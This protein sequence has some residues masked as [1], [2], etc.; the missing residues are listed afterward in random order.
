MKDRQGRRKIIS[1]GVKD[2]SGV[3]KMESKA[4]IAKKLAVRTLI[5]FVI[6]AVAILGGTLLM[7]TLLK[8]ERETNKKNQQKKTEQNFREAM[9]KYY[10]LK[11]GDYKITERKYYDN[12]VG[13]FTFSVGGETYGALGKET[14]FTNY[15]RYD[16]AADMKEVVAGIN[17]ETEVFPAG[18]YT[19]SSVQLDW[20][21]YDNMVTRQGPKNK[22]LQPMYFNREMVDDFFVRKKGESSM[23]ALT[24]F[25][26]TIDCEWSE[27]IAQEVTGIDPQPLI[28]ALPLNAG[29][30]I[31]VCCY[32]KSEDATSLERTYVYVY[33]NGTY[34]WKALTGSIE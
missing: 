30:Q 15:R 26:I 10:G 13:E 4:Q 12:Y 33:E 16:Y 34:A 29:K 23:W 14:F 27:G 11:E 7:L 19:I 1:A 3:K 5:T 25:V 31:R 21:M 32:K 22:D 8:S 20:N 28:T 2:I 9:E 24:K 17:A 6:M 18:K